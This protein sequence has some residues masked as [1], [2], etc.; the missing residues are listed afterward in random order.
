MD[1]RRFL[2]LSALGLVPGSAPAVH[3]GPAFVSSDV[4][5]L[6][7]VLVHEPGPETRK[8]ITIA[9]V[10]HPLQSFELLGE[11]AAEQHRAL[12]AGLRRSGAEVVELRD[13]VTGAIEAART[14]DAFDDWL[15]TAAPALADRADQVTAD[16]LIGADDRFAYHA[17][18]GTPGI[19]PLSTPLKFLLYVR[20]LAVMTPRGLIL[21][22]LGPRTREFEVSLLRF[23]LQWSPQLRGYPIA[24]DARRERVLLQGGDVIVADEHTLFVGVGNLTDAA[25]APC[26]AQR[27]RMDVL[28]VQLPGGTGFLG[29]GVHGRGNGLRL[30]FLHLDTILNLLAPGLVLTLPYFLEAEFSGVD[31]LTRLLKGLASEP[32]VDSEYMHRLSASLATVGLVQRFRAKTGER[33]PTVKDVK[34]LDYLQSVGYKSFPIA[35]EAPPEG[36]EA[37]KHVVEHLLPEVRFQAGNIV[38]VEPRKVL[39]V[40]QNRLTLETL[41]RGGITTE[42]FPGSELVRWHGGAHCLTLPLERD[43]V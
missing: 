27:L 19:R 36:P 4:G 5:K 13:A 42:T 35:G 18:A 15:T 32:G 11:Q 34:I 23:L 16:V 41:R 7:R 28:A 1:R 9:G 12:V 8:S 6:R 10:D 20:D 29:R 17:Q 39:A 22:N 24:F 38:A 30:K 40:D 26:L 3:H 14:A 25:A 43:P 37:V 31:P 2:A 33:D 21:A